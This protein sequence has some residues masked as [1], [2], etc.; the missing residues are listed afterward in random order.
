[1]YSDKPQ[2]MIDL[3]ESIFHTHHPTWD[4][5]HQVLMTVVTTE[6]R[7]HILTEAQKRLQGQVPTEVLDVERW[8]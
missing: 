7:R 3:L 6:E 4:N 1:M 5:H 2:A 8:A